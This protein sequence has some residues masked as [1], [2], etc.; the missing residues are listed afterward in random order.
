M[1][2]AGPKLNRSETVVV[3]L[4]PRLRYL[5]EL[6]ARRQRR[7]LSSYIEWCVDLSLGNVSLAGERTVDE[8][9][10]ELWDIDKDKR[11][12]KLARLYP[13]LLTYDEQVR[14]KEGEE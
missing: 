13:D 8:M 10:H 6:A 1:A 2:K 7:T 12:Y 11:F 5:A 3:R 14:L 9:Q 4:D